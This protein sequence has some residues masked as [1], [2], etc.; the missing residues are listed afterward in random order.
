MYYWVSFAFFGSTHIKF[1]QVISKREEVTYI[2]NLF[3]TSEFLMR[4]LIAKR[5]EWIKSQCNFNDIRMSFGILITLFEWFQ[6]SDFNV[7]NF[8]NLTVLFIKFLIIENYA[9][10]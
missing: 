5:D 7:I 2:C 8:I 1:L 4:D 9:V 6:I 10:Q 3:W